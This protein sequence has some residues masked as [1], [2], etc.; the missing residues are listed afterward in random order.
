MMAFVLF[1]NP[2][3]KLF[4]FLL[5]WL[6]AFGILFPLAASEPAAAADA[7]QV[8]WTQG[9]KDTVDVQLTNANVA[10]DGTVTA[11]ITLINKKAVWRNVSFSRTGEVF[12]PYHSRTESNLIQFL[13]TEAQKTKS[14]SALYPMVGNSQLTLEKVR[15]PAK[16]RLTIK[17]K[18]LGDDS[19]Q[20]VGLVAG[21]FAGALVKMTAGFD[22]G[23]QLGPDPEAAKDLST[24]VLSSLNNVGFDLAA[25]TMKLQDNDLLGALG[26]LSQ[27]AQD[28]P[29]AFAEV[30]G[31]SESQIAVGAKAIGRLLDILDVAPFVW[32][33]L[34]S[35]GTVQVEI[36]NV[37]AQVAPPPPATQGPGL[38]AYAGTDGNIW[39][40]NPDGTGRRRITNDGTPDVSYGRPK[41]SPDGRMLAFSRGGSF[42]QAPVGIYV[43]RDGTVSRVPNVSGCV[44]PSFYPDGQRMALICGIP[45]IYSVRYA[46]DAWFYEQS[47]YKPELAAIASVNLNGTE[48]KVLAPY[49]KEGS[50]LSPIKPISGIE[51][52]KLDGTMLIGVPYTDG[53]GAKFLGDP[54]IQR[55]NE[56]EAQPRQGETGLAL[57]DS[58]FASDG[59]NI[60]A[61]WCNYCRI[62]PPSS[63]LVSEI[64]LMSRTGSFIET[65]LIL[66]SD[67]G[68][69][70]SLSPSPDGQFIAY[71]VESVSS[72]TLRYSVFSAP[73]PNGKPQ[74]IAEGNAAVWQPVPAPLP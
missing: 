24:K 46:E 36:T 41:W 27:A 5:V 64:A 26:A 1:S 67:R 34:N 62:G 39:V 7:L 74:K 2:A 54:A 51:I 70:T 60:L 8:N 45:Q 68:F 20:S 23:E 72:N 30:L 61:W 21:G 29:G 63:R 69:V 3:V 58:N 12:V 18:K 66:P 40:I 32:D 52:S 48:W 31:L 38:I 47:R 16:S 55:L 53:A 71:A 73:I 9:D 49:A 42:T 13:E 56:F 25:F 43:Y 22:I 14:E 15:L 28:A 57:S 33:L 59:E 65:L 19:S 44:S 35:Q 11:N 4:S 10:P 50:K 17:F 37:A 6:L